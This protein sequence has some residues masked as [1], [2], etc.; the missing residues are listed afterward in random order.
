MLLLVGSA[1]RHPPR[2]SSPCRP[3]GAL[4]RP[5]RCP[6]RPRLPHQDAAGVPGAARSGPGLPALRRTSRSARRIG[7]LLVAFGAMVAGRRLVD[8]DRRAVAG[9]QR[10][11][12]S[13]ARRTNSILELTLGYNGLGRLTGNETGSV[14]G[15]G[16]MAAGAR[17][18]CC[19]CST[20]RS[21]ARSRW[22]LPAALR[23]R[24]AAL[25]FA[26]R[27]AERP[28]A[29][30][31]PD[32][33]AHLARRHRADLQ[34]DGRDLPRLLHGGARSRD[35][36]RW[37]AIG[38]WVLWQAPDLVG[39]PPGCSASPSPLTTVLA[40]ML[41][42]RTD[43][44]AVAAVRRGDRSASPPP[45]WSSASGTCP[46]GSVAAVGG[47]GARGLRWPRP[48]A[49]SLA[50][51]ATPHTGSIPSAGPSSPA[52][53]GVPGGGPGGGGGC[54]PA[55][56][57]PPAACWRRQQA[58]RRQ[59]AS[60]D[61]RAAAAPTPTSYTWVGRRGRLQLRGRLPAGHRAAGHGHRRLQRQRP[62]PDAGAVPAVR[63]GRPRST[64]SSPPAR[65]S[66]AGGWR[67]GG[68]HASSGDRGLGGR[69]LPAMTVDGV[70]L[71]DLSGGAA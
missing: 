18:A 47:G 10:A 8:R 36:R 41:L 26:R 62:E 68:R 29:A 48:A 44:V 1:V 17:P 52:A 53:G 60:T 58:A 67:P 42:D 66:V 31:G 15:G 5:G 28:G 65:V 4:A 40:F 34:P 30:F 51:A 33:V 43:F 12:T 9:R 7:H 39:S 32:A 46:C 37:S 23:P 20:P 19:G 16:G 61:H 35:R 45:S 3:P 71:Y 64:T 2:A 70:T 56:G 63:R 21:A 55:P 24:G 54:P 50:T 27:P 14:G 11:P 59:R 22:L 25:W 69:D 57:A 49:Y 13:A 6:G 38:A